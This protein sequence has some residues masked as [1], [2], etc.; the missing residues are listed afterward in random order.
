MSDINKSYELFNRL[1][2]MGKIDYMKSLGFVYNTLD[3][4]DFY[5]TERR[6]F[7][8]LHRQKLTDKFI[9]DFSIK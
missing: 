8:W 2:Q 4:Y 1:G 3:Y 9:T 7:N 5:G 6:F